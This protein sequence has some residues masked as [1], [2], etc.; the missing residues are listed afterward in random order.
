MH[1]IS[2]I[3]N[4]VMHAAYNKKKRGA[5]WVIYLASD[6]ITSLQE[7]NKIDEELIKTISKCLT[8]AKYA[9]IN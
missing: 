1:N 8:T 3:I 2:N 9:E 5:I 4:I 7:E 6:R